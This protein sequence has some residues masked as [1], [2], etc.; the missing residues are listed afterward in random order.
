MLN[1]AVS[2]TMTRQ[3]A[4]HECG[5][6]FPES[7]TQCPHCGRPSLFPNVTAAAA[8]DERDALLDRYRQTCKHLQDRGCDTVRQ[9][10]EL[11]ILD[12]AKAVLATNLNEVLRIAQADTEIFSTFYKRVQAGLVIPTG[13][14]WDVLRGVA[15]HANFP[16]YKEHIRF[17]ALSL[18]ESGVKNYG[19]CAVMLKTSMVSHRTSLFEDNNVVFTVYGQRAT[20]A[21]AESLEKGHRAVWADREK[22][23]IAKLAAKLL[24]TLTPDTYPGIVLEQGKTTEDDRFIEVHIWGSLTIR[25][26]ESVTISRRGNRPLKALIKDLDRLCKKHG[27]PVRWN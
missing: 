17:A 8:A 27:V 19:E 22:L 14:K 24:P 25:A 5:E 10:L 2:G 1:A 15:E 16:F 23:A 12:N 6:T 4:C 7:Q 11:K 3:A 13:D 9:D 20:M 21:D 18:D 26:V